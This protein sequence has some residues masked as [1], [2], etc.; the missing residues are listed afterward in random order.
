VAEQITKTGHVERA[1]IGVQA[2][3]LTPDLATAFKLDV[4]AGALIDLVQPEGPAAKAGVKPG[5]VI[6]AVA[7]HPVHDRVD[8]MREI[9]SHDVGE[10][11]VLEIIRGG[12]HY[13]ANVTLAARHEEPVEPVPAQ[14]QGVPQVGMGLRVRDLTAQQAQ[15]AGVSTHAGTATIITDVAPGSSADRASLKAGDIIVECDGAPDPTAADVQKAAAD[16][17]LVV[18]VK[19]RG[20]A[21]YAALK[22]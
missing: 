9:L 13:G 6:A 1:T 15:Q 4:R 7:G 11:A 8:L 19:R 2:Q 3:D 18:R 22:K 21:F 12:K 5:D 14:Q 10:T 16:G 17:E 20:S